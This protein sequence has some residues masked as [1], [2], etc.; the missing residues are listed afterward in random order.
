M[1][2]LKSLASKHAAVSPISVEL[3]E[4][5]RLL[6]GSPV[7]VLDTTMHLGDGFDD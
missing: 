3:L 4:G 1:Q 6:S 7:T 5:R 2:P